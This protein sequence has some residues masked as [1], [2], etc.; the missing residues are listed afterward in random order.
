MLVYD[1][2]LRISR[3]VSLTAAIGYVNTGYARKSDC[4]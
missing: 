3:M 2:M 4:F 1:F